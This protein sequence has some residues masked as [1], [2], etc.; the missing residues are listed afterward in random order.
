MLSDRD[1]LLAAIRAN[2]EEDTPRLMLA[3]WLDENG[4]PERAEFIRIQCELERL[5]ADG[6]D[7]QQIYE[8]IRDVD[9]VTRPS[10]GWPRID[11]GIDRRIALTMR[12]D[13]L[14]RRHGE[15]WLPKFAKKHKVQWG[16]ARHKEASSACR[17]GFPHHVA[18]DNPRGLKELAPR[19]RAAVPAVTL[20]AANLTDRAVDQLADADLLGWIC[21]LDLYGDCA[22]GLREF[23]Q[24]RE[25]AAVREIKLRGYLNAGD[26]VLAVTD[27]PFWT[28]LRSLDFSDAAVVDGA[29]AETLFRAENLRTLRRLSLNGGHWSADTIRAFASGT[30]TELVWLRFRNCGLDDESVELLAECPRLAK[31][32]SLDLPNNSI[33]GRAVTALLTSPHLANV[34]FLSVDHNP[35]HG[36]DAKRL[37]KATPGAIRMFHAHGCRFRTADVRALARCPR[38]RKLWYLDLDANNLGT[39]AVRELVRGFKDF[40]PPI[41]WLTHNRI[42]DRGAELLAN[43]K[44]ARSLNV[45]HLRHNYFADTGVSAITDA[46]VR[47]ILASQHLANLES[48]GVQTEDAG[49]N[50]QLRRRFR[51]H[52]VHYT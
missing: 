34:A 3:D 24:R 29:A 13:D 16:A 45:L 50:E 51:H 33:A 48:L 10:A 37:A 6:S 11:D 42:D 23:G 4:E 12:A 9:W 17:R 52:D 20:V 7:S 26:C 40:C 30:L 14:F 8:F 39:P 47:A 41:L 28:G 22:S 5:A 46:G 19:L 49:L 25:A 36:L 31:L 27:S 18:I 1:A 38:M 21:G 32:R 43:W 44:A 15:S 35:G 2:P